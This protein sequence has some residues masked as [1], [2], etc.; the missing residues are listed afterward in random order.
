M[1]NTSFALLTAVTIK[2]KHAKTSVIQQIGNHS[3][4]LNVRNKK[5]EEIKTDQAC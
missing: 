3:T 4:K 5:C 1:V 2:A